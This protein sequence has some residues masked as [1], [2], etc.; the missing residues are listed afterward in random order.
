MQKN[1]GIPEVKVKQVRFNEE[2]KI[3]EKLSQDVGPVSEVQEKDNGKTREK[4]KFSQQG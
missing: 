1:C 2:G 3:V 4:F